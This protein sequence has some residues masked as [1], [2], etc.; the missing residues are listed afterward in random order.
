MKF[1]IPSAADREQ[2]ET[3]WALVRMSLLD[4]GMPTTR[5][6][7]RALACEIEGRDHYVAVGADTPEA[8]DDPVLAIFE[9][10]NID[11]FYA[12]TFTHVAL[13]QPPYA[14]GLDESWRV[15]DFDE[16]VVGRPHR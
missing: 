11:L 7:V 5:R 12:C 9:A 16:E 10:S 3:V 14:L 1:F 6:R 2:A 15:I 4:R 13:E 8:V